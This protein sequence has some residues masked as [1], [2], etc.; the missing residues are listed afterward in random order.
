MAP[1]LRLIGID[2][3]ILSTI[4]HL[5]FSGIPAIGGS[6]LT[7]ELRVPREARSPT[8]IRDLTLEVSVV[9]RG[10]SLLGRFRPTIPVDIDLTR[11]EHE[12]HEVQLEL[13]IRREQLEAIE[14]LRAGAELK[15][16][17]RIGALFVRQDG[18]TLSRWTSPDFY[19]LNQ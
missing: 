1:Q 17:I 2:A 11:G 4:E 9:A 15:F 6:V 12:A 8:R 5:Q 16:Q 18:T 7:C 14:Q 3:N 13:P 10:T 19:T